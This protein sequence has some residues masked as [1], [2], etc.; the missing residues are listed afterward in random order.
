MEAEIKNGARVFLIDDH[1]AVRQG[2]ALLLSQDYHAV[3]GEAENRMETLERLDCSRPD[4]ALVDISLGDESGLDLVADLRKQGIPVLIYSM[5]ED[6]AT[7]EQAFGYGANGYVTKR[8]VSDVLLEAVRHVVDGKR[9]VSP[10]VAQSLARRV[11]PS[12]EANRGDLLS[13]QERRIMYMLGRGESNA[14]I[15]ERLAISAR[16]VESYCS[17]IIEKLGLEGMKALRKFA[18]RNH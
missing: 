3:C 9:Y 1:P 16:T 5:H 13:E 17:R 11:L 7:V 12:P 15:A 6:S 8:E 4:I 14:D 18:I 2:L 10:R